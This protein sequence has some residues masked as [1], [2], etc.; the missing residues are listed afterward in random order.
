MGGKDKEEDAMNKSTHAQNRYLVED[1]PNAPTPPENPPANDTTP[2]PTTPPPTAP[3]KPEGPAANTPPVPPP[4][5]SNQYPYGKPVP[6]KKG[7]VYSPYASGQDS[8][9]MIDVR[10]FSP[11]QKVKDPYTGKIF[12]VP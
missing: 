9:S 7:F 10:D 3:A 11:G 12:I 6:G 4:P 5:A 8:Q 2:P 1:N